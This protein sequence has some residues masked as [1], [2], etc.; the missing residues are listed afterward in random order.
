[1]DFWQF[2]QEEMSKQGITKAQLADNTGIDR[3][4]LIRMLKRQRTKHRLSVIN[5]MKILDALNVPRYYLI[6]LEFDNDQ[7]GA[8]SEGLEDTN[9]SIP[10]TLLDRSNSPTD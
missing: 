7:S 3:A 1:M 5:A 6:N 10:S 4:N 9:D 8:L 2:V